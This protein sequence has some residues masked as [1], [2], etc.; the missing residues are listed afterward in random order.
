MGL[1]IRKD[2]P[3]NKIQKFDV[4]V[5]QNYLTENEMAQLTRLENAYLDV[6]ED[7]ALRKIPKTMHDWEK[8]R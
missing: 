5:A 2:A 1:T 6:V 7:M 8:H 4:S 3:T